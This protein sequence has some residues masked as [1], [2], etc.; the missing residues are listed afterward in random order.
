MSRDPGKEK[1]DAEM[2]GFKVI[3][4]H[5]ARCRMRFFDIRVVV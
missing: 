2:A 4:L 1:E 5:T 3:D